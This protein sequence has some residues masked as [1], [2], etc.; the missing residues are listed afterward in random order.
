[1]VTMRVIAAT[2]GPCTK[3]LRLVIEGE[4]DGELQIMSQCSQLRS[5]R[6]HFD[7]AIGGACTINSD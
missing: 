4:I 3:L 7:T 6:Q 1:M 5:H 2:L